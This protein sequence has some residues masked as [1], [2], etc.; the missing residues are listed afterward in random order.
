MSLNVPSPEAI[1]TEN[2]FAY[3]TQMQKGRQKK[4]HKPKLKVLQK[5]KY[6]YA[7]G[8]QNQHQSHCG[9]VEH[10]CKAEYSQKTCKQVDE[11]QR[12]WSGGVNPVPCWLL[13]ER[14]A[15]QEEDEGSWLPQQVHS[16]IFSYFL[17][18]SI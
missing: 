12:G 4:T 16:Q 11:D 17:S 15:W 10:I 3:F 8:M 14:S 18:C 9:L 5:S 1:Q 13:P 6:K 2:C 7:S